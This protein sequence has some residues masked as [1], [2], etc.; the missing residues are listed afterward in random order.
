MSE[1]LD[2]RHT[3][4]PKSDQLNAEQLLTGPL[5][6]T[7]SRVTVANKQDQP[8]S[9]F[10][11]GD[12]GRPFKPCKTM[13]A[14]LAFAWSTNASDWVGRSMRLYCDPAVKFGSEE[15]GGVRISHLSDI[16]SEKI[17]ASFNVSR[18]KKAAFEV[19]R[20]PRAEGVDHLGLISA[21][22]SLEELKAAFEAATRSTKDAASRASFTAAKDKRKAELSNPSNEDDGPTFGDDTQ[23]A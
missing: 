10:Y 8:V 11:E 7:V 2:I 20:M 15:V 23:G 14:L 3:I 22:A 13:R 16:S 9:I 6:I 18:G 12:K 4:I 17:K 5:T 19:Y 1:V 21:A